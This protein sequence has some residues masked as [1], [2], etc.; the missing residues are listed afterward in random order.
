MALADLDLQIS[1]GEFVVLLGASG[2]GKTTLLR[3]I[4]GLEVP[5]AGTIRIHDKVAYSSADK[6]LLAPEHRGVGMVFQSYALW[7]HMTVFDNLAFPLR[8]GRASKEEIREGVHKALVMVGLEQRG[9]SYPGQLS[10]GQQQRVAL[11]RAT[12]A[13]PDVILFDEPLSNIDTQLRDRLRLDLLAMHHDLGF[14]AVYVTHDQFEAMAVA[15]RIVL[16][17]KG[18]VLQ[19][20]SPEQI[21]ADPHSLTAATFTG[22]TNRVR[23][24]ISEIDGDRGVVDTAIGRLVG[25]VKDPSLAVGGPAIAVFRPESLQPGPSDSTIVNRFEAR[26]EQLIFLGAQRMWVV[27]TREPGLR[28]S[29]RGSEVPDVALEA[30]LTITVNPASVFVFPAPDEQPKS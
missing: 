11:A 12:I 4:A 26:L 29:G 14:A 25:R 17:D 23:G 13:Q 27:H 24:V 20:G 2:C 19:E 1:P 3:C 28:L 18:R 21:Y 22:A 5:D 16:M 10:G 15:D 8:S 6:K 30:D 9:Q 7:P